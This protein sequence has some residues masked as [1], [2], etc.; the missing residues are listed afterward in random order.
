MSLCQFI[1]YQYHDRS[2]LSNLTINNDDSVKLIHDVLAR[3]HCF[4]YHSYEKN[5]FT[6]SELKQIEQEILNEND[7]NDDVDF[8]DVN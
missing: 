8:D 3:S 4:L 7:D 6:K 1:Q 5:K 2:K